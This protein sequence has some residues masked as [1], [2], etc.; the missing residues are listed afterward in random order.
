MYSTTS[1][2][3][4]SENKLFPF[5]ICKQQLQYIRL[6]WNYQNIQNIPILLNQ[7]QPQLFDIKVN[8]TEI[9]ILNY[10]LGQQILKEKFDFREIFNLGS[11]YF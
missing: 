4:L 3:I 5:S 7:I 6:I 11:D 1:P 9:L 10:N 2:V 8:V